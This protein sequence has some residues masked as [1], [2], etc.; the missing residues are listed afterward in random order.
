LAFV[1]KHLSKWQFVGLFAKYLKKFV[2]VE[3]ADSNF[4]CYQKSMI[5]DAVGMH[6]AP[7]I[8][9]DA[10]VLDAVDVHQAPQKKFFGL[11]SR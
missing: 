4:G 5:L 1:R 3:V 7:M 9:V 8:V 11:I 2:L 10:F 6:Q